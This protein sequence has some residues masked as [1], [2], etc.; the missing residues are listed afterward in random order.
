MS[1]YPECV[2]TGKD[3]IANGGITTLGQ[4]THLKS[5]GVKGVMVGRAAITDPRIFARMKNI[6]CPSRDVIKNEFL[7]LTE[8]YEEHQRYKKSVLRWM[9]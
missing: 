7:E 8:K 5:V 3:I 6:E 9:K 4:V 1:I 2:A